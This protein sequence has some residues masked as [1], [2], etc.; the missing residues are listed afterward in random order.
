MDS[1]RLYAII[2]RLTA[3]RPGAI[4]ADHGDQ[5]RAALFDL[6]RRGDLP[7]AEK[8]HD[9]NIQKPY[10][11]SLLDGGKR[12]RSDAL[13]F[14]EG[15]SAYWRFTLLQE[16]AFEALLRRYLLNRSLP[17][18]RIGHIEFAISDAF[19]SGAGHPESGHTSVA[20]LQSRWDCTPESLA[21]QLELTF[22]SPTVFS[23]GTDRE[24]GERRWHS[25][26]DAPMLFSTLRKK[27]LSLGGAAPGDEFDQWTR[28]FVEA[29]PLHL[30]TRTVVVERR[31]VNGFLGR[32]RFRVRGDRRWL[33]LLHLL[34]DLTFWTG[35][36]YQ[37]TRGMGRVQR[38]E[39]R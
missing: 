34:A 1:L 26:P 24:T 37:T 27:W 32:T 6:V 33:P 14:G 21:T 4:P 31:P 38:S 3:I 28:Q 9:Q 13:H 5:A 39:A 30:E 25:M 17:H 15:D 29:E 20:E 10:T 12:D 7:L 35:A 8:L 16:A 22:R 36:G 11:I 23:L 19:A 2:F 18:V